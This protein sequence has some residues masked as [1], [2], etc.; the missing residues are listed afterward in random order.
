M[1]EVREGKMRAMM[2]VLLAATALG[3]GACPM[4]AWYDSTMHALLGI[5]GV[6]HFSAM[7]ATVGKIAG[8]DWQS[9]RRVQPRGA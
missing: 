5:D 1:K 7:T 8:G 9:D 3:L 6:E 4:G 2:L